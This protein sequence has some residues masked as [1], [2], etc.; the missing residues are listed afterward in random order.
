MNALI[1]S[2]WLILVRVVSD[3]VYTFRILCGYVMARNLS[4]MLNVIAQHLN[5]LW[6][7]SMNIVHGRDE[8]SYL[9]IFV[10][11]YSKIQ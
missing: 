3:Y 11:I 4:L 5:L 1:R 10:I 8:K 2:N 6:L 7:C 9:Y